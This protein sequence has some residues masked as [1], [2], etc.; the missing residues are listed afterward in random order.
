MD[1]ESLL[2]TRIAINELKSRDAAGAFQE[3]GEALAAVAIIEPSAVPAVR[4]AFLDREKRGPT[5]LGFGMAVPH[6]FHE[7]VTAAHLVV[8]RSSD[9][10]EMKAADGR[11]IKLMFCLVATESQRPAYL[12]ML[13][14]IARI[15][16]DKDW[17]R[18]IERSATAAQVFDALIKGDKALP[19]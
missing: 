12:Y 6:I 15:A 2:V 1:L 14:A 17:R 16:R 5:S 4:D 3:V 18:F 8:A 10:I 11:P 7:G 9:G 19:R 13:G